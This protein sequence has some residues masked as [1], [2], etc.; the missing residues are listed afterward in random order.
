MTS[1]ESPG[2]TSWWGAAQKRV[3]EMGSAAVGGAQERLEGVRDFL[4][5]ARGMQPADEPPSMQQ[6]LYD[7]VND[8]LNMPYWQR[9]LACGLCFFAG[10]AMLLLSTLL[11]P[12][13][14]LRPEKFALSFTLGN[15]LC[16]GSTCFLVGPRAQLDAMFHPVRA[17]A[18]FLFCGAMAS[19]IFC[20]LFARHGK[21]ILVLVSLITEL[22]ALAWYALSYI[23]YGRALIA[24]IFPGI[25]SIDW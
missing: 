3:V 25:T 22:C 14:I 17:S 16:M 13:I 11:L 7:E 6:E 23:P 18:A 8:V 1:S 9:V 10:A 12:V 4:D 21:Y 24:S 19:T 20:A 15:L 5:E 2:L